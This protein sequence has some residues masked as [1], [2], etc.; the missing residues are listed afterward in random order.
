M[1]KPWNYLER[2]CQN[3]YCSL[4]SPDKRGTYWQRSKG[5]LNWFPHFTKF[6]PLPMVW[7][8]YGNFHSEKFLVNSINISYNVLQLGR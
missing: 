1:V 8:N 3:L 2:L 4:H 6:A 5:K 7:M